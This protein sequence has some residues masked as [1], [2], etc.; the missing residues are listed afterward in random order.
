MKT[1]NNHHLLSLSLASAFLI[2]VAPAQAS[3]DYADTIAGDTKHELAPP[4]FEDVDYA[5]ELAP[6][7]KPAIRA[8][9]FGLDP[10]GSGV[11]GEPDEFDVV[12]IP[13]TNE[14]PGNLGNDVYKI[15]VPANKPPVRSEDGALAP[16]IGAGLEPAS[17]EFEL[18]PQRPAQQSCPADCYPPGGNGRVNIDDLQA[19]L[20]DYAVGTAR[21]DIA[22]SYAD[23]TFGDGDVDVDDLIAVLV[24]FGNC[25]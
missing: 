6:A 16:A 20:T 7:T 19:F 12:E 14:Q 21:C 13:A 11:L 17:G 4:S 18:A 25:P 8:Q 24:A 23:G 1:M 2:T 5:E 10:N 9:E 3:T 15:F 22:P